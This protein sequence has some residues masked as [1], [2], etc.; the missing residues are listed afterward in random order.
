MGKLDFDFVFIDGEHGPFGLDQLARANYRGRTDS[1]PQADM[2]VRGTK[3]PRKFLGVAARR[4]VVNHW[5]LIWPG[6]RDRSRR[7]LVRRAVP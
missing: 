7:V 4:R 2:V 1:E 3:R 6:Y 5:W